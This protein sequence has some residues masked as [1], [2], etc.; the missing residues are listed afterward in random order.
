VEDVAATPVVLGQR[1]RHL[2]N[3]RGLTLAQL[4]EQVGRQ[5]PYLSQLENGK[6]EAT[7][8]LLRRVADALGTEVA[9]LLDPTPPTRR[10]ELE[11]HLRRAQNDPVYTQLGLAPLTLSNKVPD[12]VLEHLVA[13]YTELKRQRAVRARTPEE[14]R[15]GN[16][17]LRDEMRARDNHFPEIEQVARETLDAI[18]H[19]GRG[20]VGRSHLG[21]IAAHFGFAV[22]SVPDLPAAVRSLTDLRRRRIY[23]PQ[24]DQLHSQ[25]IRT[26]VLQALGHL[27]LGHEEPGDFGRFLRQRVEAN[28]FAG[29]VLMPERT[30]VPALQ[31]AKDRRA[32]S[33]E[34]IEEAYNVSYEMAAHRFTNLA[35]AHLGIPLHFVRSDANGVIWK[36]YEN[37]GVPFPADVDGAIEGQRLCRFWATRTALGAADR[38][39]P[40]YQYTDTPAGTYWCVTRLDPDDGDSYHAITI[41]CRF[42]DAEYF[43]GR[44]TPLRATSRCPDGPCCRQPAPELASRWDGMAWP[45]PRPHSH[46]LAVIPAGRFPGVDQ[47]EVYE[48]LE[49]HAD[50]D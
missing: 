2:R 36:A 29:A 5:A 11:L 38:F 33:I 9:D 31:A 3:Q 12:E 37:D 13:L 27:A 16:A 39:S 47:T 7:L 23:I 49:R 30:L 6:R 25:A 45:S 34:A 41:G 48:F 14:A 21:A 18:E 22:R 1:I 40:H 26:V 44:D 19:D 46:V 4:G 28:Y 17:A 20:P 8:S 35:T 43:R 10:D 15:K 42:A 50:D 32:L 24:R